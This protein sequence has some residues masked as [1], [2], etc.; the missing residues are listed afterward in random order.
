MPRKKREFTVDEYEVFSEEL[1]TSFSVDWISATVKYH[2]GARIFD[3][4]AAFDTISTGQDVKPM[5]GYNRAYRWQFGALMLWHSEKREMGVHFILSGSA[6]KALQAEDID[7]VFL[8]NKLIQSR[9]KITMIHL[10][11]DVFGSTIT[12]VEMYRLFMDKQYTGRAQTASIIQNSFGGQTLYIG[13][14][15]S[16][17][18]YRLYDKAAE[19][20]IIGRNW[21]RIELV[22][23]GDYAQ[24]FAYKFASE[25]TLDMSVQVFRGA[26]KA[27][28]T[29]NHADW[30]KAMEGKIEKLGLPEAKEKKTKEWLLTQVAPAMARYIANTGDESIIELFSAE[31]DAQ[32]RKEMERTRSTPQIE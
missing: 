25:R 20:S 15:N 7:A 5:H 12:P 13:S 8:L 21:K 9:A 32:Y 18:F 17:R 24:Q 6:L 27:M 3:F 11:L 31:L 30:V 4:K 26:I 16:E 22:L 14:W 29:Y 28:A 10:A 2:E 19:Q 1:H 23:K